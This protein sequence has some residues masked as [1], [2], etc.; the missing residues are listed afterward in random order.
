MVGN[1]NYIFM[2]KT[3]VRLG[4]NVWRVTYSSETIENCENPTGHMDTLSQNHQ[5]ISAIG[6]LQ[7]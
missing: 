2:G 1:S 5:E 7:Q 6:I 4:K 3:R